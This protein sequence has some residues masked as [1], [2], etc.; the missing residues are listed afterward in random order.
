ML[1]IF[2]DTT[3]DKHWSEMILM[4]KRTSKDITRWRKYVF[5]SPFFPLNVTFDLGWLWRRPKVR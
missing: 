4:E 5:F 2:D 3:E 1:M